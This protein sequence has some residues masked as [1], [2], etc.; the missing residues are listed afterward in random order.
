MKTTMEHIHKIGDIPM[1]IMYSDADKVADVE[2]IKLFTR[3][4]NS[5][6]IY[7]KTGEHY[8]MNYTMN[9]NARMFYTTLNRL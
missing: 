4:I 2:Q 3:E 1:M 7:I 5:S 9:Q 8:I 6:E